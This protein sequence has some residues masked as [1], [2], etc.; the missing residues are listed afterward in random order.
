MFMT[1]RLQRAGVKQSSNKSL[2]KIIDKESYN[3]GPYM[4]TLLFE[5]DSE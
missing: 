5:E 1:S 3:F 2:V 4:F